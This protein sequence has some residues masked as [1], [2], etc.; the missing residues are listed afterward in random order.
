MLE[1]YG[2]ALVRERL[3]LNDG[4]EVGRY[5]RWE[6]GKGTGI[7]VLTVHAR[8][9]R[10]LRSRRRPRSLGTWA[11]LLD[12]IRGRLGTS[13]YDGMEREMSLLSHWKEGRIRTVELVC[14]LEDVRRTKPVRGRRIG[15]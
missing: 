11:T 3:G 4:G 2:R 12:A 1:L 14:L 5:L 10:A 6:Y 7:G 8:R 15:P 9:G 13:R